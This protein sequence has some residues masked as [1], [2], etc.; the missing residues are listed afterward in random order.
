[1]PTSTAILE[2]R[3]DAATLSIEDLVV[4][5]LDG[6]IRVPTWQRPLNWDA[7]DIELLLDSIHR[8][9]P[10]GTLLFWKR[11]AEACSMQV[12]PVRID[13]SSR[14]DA[15]WVVDGQQRITALTGVLAGSHGD[16]TDPY[17][18]F[19]DLEGD[20][21]VRA[22]RRQAP[23]STWLPLNHV[24]DSEKLLLWLHQSK[25]ALTD[26]HTGRAIRLGK[27]VR[28]YQ[29]PAYIVDSATE[30]PLRTIFE[31]SNSTGK[32]LKKQDIFDALHSR[33][34]GSA[35]SICFPIVA[36]TFQEQSGAAFN[37]AGPR[38]GAGSRCARSD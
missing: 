6:R 13:A 24:L 35:S 20:T 26:V 3:P 2:R 19:F 7:G 22:K 31:R 17:S 36:M 14:Q 28:E 1:M 8:G 37:R 10:I 33:V 15:L 38:P 9:Y 4:D 12:G 5:V 18:L 23:A 11:P 25:P 29:V 16:L 34:I 32:T 30:E 21:F 27:R